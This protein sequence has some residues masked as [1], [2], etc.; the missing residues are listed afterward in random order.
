MA[1]IQPATGDETRAFT[2]GER[3]YLLS[4]FRGPRLISVRSGPRD[5]LDLIEATGGRAGMDD[6][7]TEPVAED[8]EAVAV[9]VLVA[10][11][12]S[13]QPPV[14]FGKGLRLLALHSQEAVEV[15]PFDLH[16]APVD[17]E[18]DVLTHMMRDRKTG[19]ERRVDPRLVSLLMAIAEHYQGRTLH[20]V[21]GYRA[22]GHGTRPSSYHTRGMAADIRVPG[23]SPEE[24]CSLA[25]KLGA[26]GVGLYPVERFVHVDVRLSPFRWQEYEP[27]INI[28]M[29]RN[30]ERAPNVIRE[31][32]HEEEISW[33]DPTVS[34]VPGQEHSWLHASLDENLKW[35]ESPTKAIRSTP[36][37]KPALLTFADGISP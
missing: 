5:R 21:S 4:L 23:V 36:S 30:P 15:R 27:G 17:H 24:L 9:P 11:T 32:I 37:W 20:L 34:P 10:T 28:P 14:E 26:R 12:E 7:A 1:A 35:N 18:F 13:A 8:G 2:S 16:G 6:H 31:E 19:E 22:E 3:R 29:P 33:A 25:A